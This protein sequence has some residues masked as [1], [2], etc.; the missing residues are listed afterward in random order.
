MR[1]QGSEFRVPSSR[2]QGSEFRVRGS[3]LLNPTLVLTKRPEAQPGTRNPEPRTLNNTLDA[4]GSD[5]YY[6]SHKKQEQLR[7][8]TASSRP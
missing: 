6:P 2:V 8:K 4:A 1:D 3:E 5:G 7:K